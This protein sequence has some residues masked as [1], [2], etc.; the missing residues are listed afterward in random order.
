MDEDDGVNES[1]DLYVPDLGTVP[2]AELYR[3]YLKGEVSRG[4]GIPG[5]WIQF[6]E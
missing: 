5:P 1:G 3:S 6:R 4:P 2:A